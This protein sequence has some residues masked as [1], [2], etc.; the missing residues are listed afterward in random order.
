[1]MRR[2]EDPKTVIRS[3][4]MS[5]SMAGVIQEEAKRRRMNVSSYLRFCAVSSIRRAH[6]E[7]DALMA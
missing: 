1:M 2:Y 4:R 6:S 7:Q 5:P 3:I